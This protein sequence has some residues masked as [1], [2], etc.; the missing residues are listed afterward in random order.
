MSTQKIY[1]DFLNLVDVMIKLQ[2]QYFDNGKHRSDLLV[3]KKTKQEVK[4]CIVRYKESQRTF[5]CRKYL[6][7]DL[8]YRCKFQC[9]G[10][11]NQIILNKKT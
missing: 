5:Y 4:N 10:C 6:D 3:Y 9:E 7:T 1:D 2:D 11:D 8:V